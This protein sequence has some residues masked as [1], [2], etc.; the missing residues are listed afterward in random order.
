MRRPVRFIA[1]ACSSRRAR[2]VEAC[3]VTACRRWKRS[4]TAVGLVAT[5]WVA[6]ISEAVP[7]QVR[8][9]ARIEG[10]VTSSPTGTLLRVK[11]TDEAGAPLPASLV[12]LEVLGADGKRV[13][14]PRP[15]TCAGASAPKPAPRHPTPDTYG[16]ETDEQGESCVSAQALPPATSLRLSFAGDRLHDATSIDVPFDGATTD[17]LAPLLRFAPR[18]DVIDLEQER[19]SVRVEVKIDRASALRRGGAP[20]PSREGLALS[21]E[22]GDGRALGSA[23]TGGDGRAVFEVRTTDV[24]PP[25]AGELRVRFD[26]NE[27]LAKV[28]AT[29]TIARQAEARLVSPP[30]PDAADPEGTA[31]LEVAIASNHGAID[32]G[33]V[34]AL[35]GGASVG[36]AEV[37]GGH[38]RV[39]VDVPATRASSL[40][41]ELRYVPASPF[42]RPGEPI[43]VDLAIRRPSVVREGLV[44]LAVLAV[45]AWIV[46][47]WRRAPKSR[48][49]RDEQGAPPPSGRPEVAVLRPSP[50]SKGWSG[51]VVDAHDGTPVA[52]ATLRIVA[53]A[54]QGDGVVAIATTDERG[55]FALDAPPRADARLAVASPAHSSYEQALPPPSVLR[56]AIVTRRR[57]VLDRLVRWAKQQGAPFDS[58]PEPTPGHVRRAATRT[59]A[60]EVATWAQHVEHAAFGAA[61]VDASVE[62]QIRSAEPR[63]PRSP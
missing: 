37:T 2:D 55:E 62:E 54:F 46:A 43:E 40:A 10:A 30:A 27:E 52:G 44:V 36:A 7:I 14:L 61:P 5:L 17:R 35:I 34:E 21:L 11:V 1:G 13:L 28:A 32:G 41:V 25:G 51:V 23:T 57:A 58:G 15:R 45:A 19:A 26:G 9:G 42:W 8:G 22:D 3:I 47:G 49:Q 38:A 20:L 4:L 18:V 56:V 24:G 29:T 33:V 31:T 59:E 50:S 63:R 53:P 12:T 60:H 39:V 6:R 16:V 48:A